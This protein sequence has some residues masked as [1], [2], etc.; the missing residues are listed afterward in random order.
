MHT[1]RNANQ[2][3]SEKDN[4]DEKEP[5]NNIFT[6]NEPIFVTNKLMLVIG[7]IPV[8]SILAITTLSSFS[9]SSPSLSQIGARDLQC[10]HQGA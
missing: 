1:P 6:A 2:Q 4:R 9:N 5:K 8:A 7:L 10:P 3:E